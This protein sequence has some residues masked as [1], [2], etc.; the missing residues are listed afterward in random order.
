MNN[1]LYLKTFTFYQKQN[2]INKLI[3]LDINNDMIYFFSYDFF[4]VTYS[5]LK[6][7]IASTVKPLE[8]SLNNNLLQQINETYNKHYVNDLQKEIILNMT[9]GEVLQCN[10]NEL[11]LKIGSIEYII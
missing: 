2:S 8:S 9:R 11:F 4:N 10:C 5:N 3:L 1:I 6:Q 7:T